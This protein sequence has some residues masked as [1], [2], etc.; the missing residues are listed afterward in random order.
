M[1]WSKEEMLGIKTQMRSEE[2]GVNKRSRRCEQREERRCWNMQRGWSSGYGAVA[3][4]QWRWSKE[5]AYPTKSRGELAKETEERLKKN[6]AAK[7]DDRRWRRDVEEMLKRMEEMM[8]EAK[9]ELIKLKK[10]SAEEAKEML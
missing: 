3:M 9:E 7:E 1:K 5:M 8:K 2:T 6:E 10:D 4:E